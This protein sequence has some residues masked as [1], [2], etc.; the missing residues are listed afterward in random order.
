[1]QTNPQ[2][3]FRIKPLEWVERDIHGV[4]S[5]SADTAFSGY[6]INVNE[7]TGQAMAWLCPATKLHSGT[8]A[9]CKAAAE[10]HWQE[11]MRPAL[12]LAYDAEE[13]RQAW[14]PRDVLKKL[15]E[16]AELL[17][18]HCN[19]DGDGYEQIGICVER[20]KRILERMKS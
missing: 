18:H 15:T 20:A 7:D 6:E 3:L 19:Y 2:P 13:V 10:Q 1:M 11:T 8:L 14:P 5:Y 4:S 16:A 12:E 17:L 9:E